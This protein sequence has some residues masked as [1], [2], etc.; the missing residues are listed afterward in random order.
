MPRFALLSGACSGHYRIP[1]MNEGFRMDV[2]A[3]IR[4]Y[5]RN[6]PR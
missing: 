3:P 2:I 5:L 1:G 6:K 4:E